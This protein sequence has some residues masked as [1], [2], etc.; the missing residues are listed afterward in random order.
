MTINIDCET[1]KKL[2]LAWEEIIR[3]VVLAA[4]DY[5]KCPYEAE[6][7]VVLTDNPGI[8]QVNLEYRDVDSPTDVLSFPMIEYDRLPILTGWRKILPAA[9]TRRAGS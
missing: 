7:N 4:M 6:V 2:N 3:D 8:R 9:L 5:E 1:E